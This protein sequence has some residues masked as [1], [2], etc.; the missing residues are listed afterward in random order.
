MIEPEDFDR[1]QRFVTSIGN[2]ENAKCCQ[3]SPSTGAK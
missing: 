2:I 3:L 1:G